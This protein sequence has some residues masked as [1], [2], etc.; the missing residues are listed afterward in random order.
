MT[1]SESQKKAHYK[2]ERENIKR[3]PLDVQKQHYEKIKAAADNVNESVN[4]YIKRAV[5]MRMESE[6]VATS[7]QNELNN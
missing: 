3:I 4:G 1:I 6:G 7:Q 2:Y 5:D